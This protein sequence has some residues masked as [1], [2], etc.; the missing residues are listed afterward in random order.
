MNN[1]TIVGG[2]GR[3]PELKFSKD[4]KAIATF[5][6]ATDYGRDENKKTTWHNVVAFGSLAENVVKSVTKG[7]RVIVS[8]RLDVSEY[9]KDGEK[10][11]KVELVADA[12][13][14]ELR[15]EPVV[16][17]RT[18]SYPQREEDF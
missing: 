4:Q 7:T 2:V 9:E 14:L 1:I 18:P 11:K 12:V 10:K 16:Q 13:G 6:V 17:H 3:D 8:G 15:F 5:S